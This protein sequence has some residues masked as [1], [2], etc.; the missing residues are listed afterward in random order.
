MM[1]SIAMILG[2]ILA[3]LFLIQLFRGQK[4]E[5]LVEG[6]EEKNFPLKDIYTVGFCWAELPPLRLRGVLFERL[7]QNAKV[8]YGEMYAEYYANVYYAMALSFFHFILCFGCLL[9]GWQDSRNFFYLGI[10]LAIVGLI[11]SCDSMQQKLVKRTENCETELPEV[12]S[13]MAILVNSSMILRDAWNMVGGR[14]E[15]DIYALMRDASEDIRNGHADSEAIAKFGRATNSPEIIKFTSALMQSMGKGAGELPLFLAR[16]SS[17]L[18][19]EKKQRLLQKGE[20]AS[21][22]LLMPIMLIFLGIIIIIL[23]S[24]FAGISL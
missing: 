6:L 20:Q 4:Y 15:G 2:T 21:A 19:N 17:D 23:S 10:F 13:T 18:W 3:I 16:Q 22:K 11:Y 7:E 8:L 12:V 24:A 1:R 9:A 14:G 5:E